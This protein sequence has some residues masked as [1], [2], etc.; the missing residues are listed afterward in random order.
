MRCYHIMIYYHI[1]E[2]ASKINVEN[3]NYAENNVKKK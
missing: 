3:M 2:V 1:I